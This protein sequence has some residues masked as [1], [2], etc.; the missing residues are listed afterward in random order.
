M[1]NNY[2]FKTQIASIMEV[3]ANT[4]V[5]E[6]CKLID[7]DYA[8]LRLEISQ[9]Q[10][11]NRLL[12]RKV[13]MME[14][15]M[16]RE[17]AERTIREC[18]PS[19]RSRGRTSVMERNKGWR[20]GGH[21]VTRD[22]PLSSQGESS[23]RGRRCFTE[24]PPAKR[25]P[26]VE[27]PTVT[28]LEGPVILI[29]EEIPEAVLQEPVGTSWKRVVGP[30]CDGMVL[31]TVTAEPLASSSAEQPGSR[32]NVVEAVRGDI[33]LPLAKMDEHQERQTDAASS[34]ILAGFKE[35][36]LTVNDSVSAAASTSDLSVPPPL[37]HS[38]YSSVVKME[39]PSSCSVLN[40]PSTSEGQWPGPVDVDWSAG[41][42]SEQTQDHGSTSD[43]L[44]VSGSDGTPRVQTE[45]LSC[46]L[47]ERSADKMTWELRTS[48]MQW[49]IDTEGQPEGVAPQSVSMTRPSDGYS[50][51]SLGSERCQTGALLQRTSDRGHV[52]PVLPHVTNNNFVAEM[53]NVASFEAPRKDTYKAKRKS[54]TK[55]L[56]PCL[57]C[58]R[59][60]R[61]PKQVEIHHRVHTG[62]KPFRCT[63]CPASFSVAG[64]LKRHQRVHT[65]EKPFSC[66]QCD[67]HFSLRHQLQKHLRCHSGE[68]PF[69][70]S[71][72][73][74]RF[75]EKSYVRLH[76]Q[77]SHSIS[78]RLDA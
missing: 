16:A 38:V 66:P 15:K 60:F 59:T 75:A 61:C 13:Q 43:T 50:L 57:L 62:E 58:G 10:N 12:K 67:R 9:S 68:K 53:A 27:E 20:G 39:E 48:C 33:G 2:A 44:E 24:D 54:P 64:N 76:L 51:P 23:W 71:R 73:G 22:R 30:A 5:A 6:I 29:K 14:L 25:T 49:E 7:N 17:R 1:T 77:R 47:S 3:L 69:S 4:A 41:L 31:P 28:E 55:K 11:E 52:A 65:G 74:K 78:T 21:F 19:A 18:V 35:T 72:C 70:C 8:V 32:H 42:A 36:E 26:G 56:F 37:E 34:F 46:A 63:L 45:R 40:R